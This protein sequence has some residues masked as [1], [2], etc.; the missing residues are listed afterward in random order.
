MIK[1]IALFIYVVLP[2][3]FGST[4]VAQSGSGSSFLDNG[5]MTLSK[6]TS[7]V[8]Y[9]EKL[10]L[11]PNT[12]WVIDGD[13]YLYSKQVWIAPTAKIT[14]TGRIILKDPGVKPILSRLDKSAHL[15]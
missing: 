10:Y 1:K 13:L 8:V 15:D 6:G 2:I 14:G 11:G 9:S 7:D 5:N 3:C 4:A 12:N